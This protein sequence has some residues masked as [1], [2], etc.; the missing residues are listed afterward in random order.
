MNIIIYFYETI[1][2][3]I[4]LY[5]LTYL[6]NKLIATTSYEYTRFNTLT[7]SDLLPTELI[8]AYL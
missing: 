8:F 6:T 2:Y 7:E 1:I 3:Y 5:I 4:V